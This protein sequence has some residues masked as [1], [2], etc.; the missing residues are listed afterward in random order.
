MR[1]DSLIHLCGAVLAMTEGE[2]IIVFG[3][4]S[5]LGRYPELGEQDD[6]PFLATLRR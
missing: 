4:A 5:L 6:S 1:L 3:S 2:R